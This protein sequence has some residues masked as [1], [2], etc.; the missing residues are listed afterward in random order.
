MKTSERIE[1]EC[2]LYLIASWRPIVLAAD[3]E[4]GLSRLRTSKSCADQDWF[5]GNLSSL[6]KR[7]PMYLHPLAAITRYKKK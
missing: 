5:E 3:A 6:A 7:S 4:F 2:K 1:L